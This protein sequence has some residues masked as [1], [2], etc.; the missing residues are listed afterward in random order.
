MQYV[1]LDIHLKHINACIMDEAG[2]IQAERKLRNDPD[3]FSKLLAYLD[4]EQCK[5]TI[6]ACSCWEYVYDYLT[7]AGFQVVLANPSRIKQYQNN[8]KKTD[9]T[10]AKTLAN[11]LRTNMLPTAYAAPSHVRDYR[12]LTRHKTSLTRLAKARS[13]GEEQNSRNTDKERHCSRL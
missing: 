3:D 13:K 7:D 2:Q 8:K 6:E 11:L 1:G 5:I 12:Q 4:R 10:D 9:K